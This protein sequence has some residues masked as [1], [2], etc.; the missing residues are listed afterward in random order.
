MTLE[1]QS[2]S[3]WAGEVLEG[4]SC[5]QPLSPEGR[6]LQDAAG[7]ALGGV[8]EDPQCA[9]CAPFLAISSQL[10]PGVTWQP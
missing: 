6:V 7:C 5:H 10:V 2:C 9:A 1:G 4:E 3:T 8:A